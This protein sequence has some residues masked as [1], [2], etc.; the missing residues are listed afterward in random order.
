[1]MSHKSNAVSRLHGE[2]SRRMW[3]DVWKGFEES[4]IPISHVTNGA[5]T[6][7]YT[8]P[9]MREVL[10]TYLGTD[11]G[12]HLSDPERWVRLKD[13]PDEVLWRARYEMRQRMIDFL[14]DD[15]SRNWMKF[16]Y[17]KTWQEDLFGKINPEALMIG[18]ARRFAPYKRADLIFSDPDRLDRI[19]NHPTRPVHLIF[20]GKA[21]PSDQMGKDLIKKAMDFCKE[22]RFRGKIFFI[23]GYDIRIARHLVQGVDVWLNNP[24]R[25]LEASGTSG[26]K[27]VVNG[28]LNLSVSDGWWCEGYEEN[29]GWNIGPVVRTLNEEPGNVDADE[30]DAQSL[31][32]LLENNVVPLFYDRGMPGLPEK[33]I[34][35][36]KRSMQT[37]APKFNTERMLVEYYHNLYL[38]TAQREHILYENNY[39]IAREL[40][41][42]KGKLPMRFS[43]LHLIDVSVEGIRVDQILVERPLSVRVRIHPGKME[44]GELLL[45]LVIGKTD[46]GNGFAETPECLPLAL[47][48]QGQDGVLTFV[49]DYTVRQNGTYAY[50]IRVLPNHPHLAAKQETGLVYWG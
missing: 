46:G 27:V 15:L 30:E 31:Y 24:R 14:R 33:W 6:L 25:P 50:G 9:R 16:G 42:W 36:V 32:T 43:S 10:D 37:L 19:L 13:I 26:E 35:M 49:A 18:F 22:E 1:K 2:V 3:R 48:E 29:N 21:H 12:R 23:E 38:P 34:A 5:H 11:W 7:S 39:R 40:A 8:A 41:E 44:P 20:A 17:A 28:V 47:A 45:E 4:D